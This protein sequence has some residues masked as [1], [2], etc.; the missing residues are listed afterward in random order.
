[1]T[2]PL[3]RLED[4]LKAKAHALGFEL[5]GIA[6]ASPADSFDRLQDWLDQGFAG[7][8]GYMHRQAEARKHPASILPPVRSVLM[9]GV[10]YAGVRSQ[11]SGVRSQESGVSGQGNQGRLTGKVARY[12]QGA[13]YHDVLRGKLNELLAWLQQEVPGVQGRGVV[14][15]APLLERDFARRA[16]L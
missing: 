11:E 8:M 12:A 16:G 15:T 3:P 6:P 9:V 2:A 4:R 10:N 14:D 5:A 13:D 7:E 1:M